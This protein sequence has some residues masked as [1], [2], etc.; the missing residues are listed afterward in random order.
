MSKQAEGFIARIFTKEGNSGKGKWVADSFKIKDAEGEEDPYFYQMGFRDKGKLDTPPN[1]S[2]G[3]YIRFSYEDKDATARTY[4]KGSGVKVADAP[5]PAPVAQ[6][7]NT[8]SGSKS[9]TQQNIHYQNSRTAAIELVDVLLSNDALATSTAKTKAGVAKR[10]D[11]ICAAVDKLTVK[12]FNDLESFR[13]LDTVADTGEVDT[14]PDDELP[15][16]EE[17]DVVVTDDSGDEPID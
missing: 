7:S 15:D 9:S 11:E 5:K 4:V 6:Q 12:F 2:E 14:S 8:V 16:Q 3:D 17:E 13:L 10:F 1:F